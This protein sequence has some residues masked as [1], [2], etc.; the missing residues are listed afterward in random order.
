M[1]QKRNKTSA[2]LLLLLVILSCTS[3]QNS[4]EK[5]SREE[6]SEVKSLFSLN[7]ISAER[8]NDTLSG[9]S[10]LNRS[11]GFVWGA[12]VTKGKDG[13]Y[14]MLYSSWEC[15]DHIPHFVTSWLTHSKIAYAVS[16]EPDRNF[17]FVKFILEGAQY[18]GDSSAWDAQ[19]VHNPHLKRFD[20]HFY[21]YYIGSRDPGVQPNGSPGEQ[22]SPRDRIQQSQ[23]IGVIKFN[24]FEDLVNGNFI[25]P[26]SPILSPRTR[27]KP[28]NILDPSPEGTTPL[29]DNIVVVNPSVVKSP[30]GKYLLYFKGNLYE[31]GWKGVHGVAVGN[32]PDGPFIAKN[33]FMFDIKLEDG[34]LASAEDPYVWY[35]HK[36]QSY[37]AIIKDFSGKITGSL[38]GLAILE[39]TDGFNW[40]RHENAPYIPLEAKLING[41][42][43]TLNRLER[44]QL[45][46]DDSGNPL[47]LFCAA[48]IIPIQ[49]DQQGFSFNIHIPLEQ[50]P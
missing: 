41:E 5:T 15:G 20:D 14:H 4:S 13:R 29:P 18:S 1:L 2:P 22:L 39:S 24:S 46:F 12:S 9:P 42:T 23:K 25:R 21:L 11:D 10:I 26:K 8:V 19:M 28:N 44:P 17:K 40:K 34:S 43:I 27:V 48:S 3:Q 45:L 38:P 32:S 37:F 47:T 30:E 7:P 33:D 31:N 50:H 35:S 16:D 49:R 36:Y 6:Q